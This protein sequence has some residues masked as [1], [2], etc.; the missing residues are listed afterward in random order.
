MWC[1]FGPI[2]HGGVPRSSIAARSVGLSTVGEWMKSPPSRRT[3]VIR[4]GNGRR[5]PRAPKPISGPSTIQ[6]SRHT[7]SEEHTSELQSLMRI[8][9]AV[10]CLKNKIYHYTPLYPHQLTHHTN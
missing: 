8:S 6:M 5:I 10:F 1:V 4:V 3:I 2:I 7:R 9:Y